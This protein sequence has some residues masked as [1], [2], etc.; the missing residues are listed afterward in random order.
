LLAGL[1]ADVSRVS[2]DVLALPIVASWLAGLLAC[3]LAGL[4]LTLPQMQP[5]GRTWAH[6][7]KED[8]RARL[9]WLDLVGVVGWLVVMG[10]GV[11][12]LW[13][14]VLLVG[15][16]CLVLVVCVCGG[17]PTNITQQFSS[18]LFAT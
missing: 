11:R 12:W 7:T 2:A 9:A 4:L 5:R 16:V 3:W 10:S 15:G 8:G 1:D 6:A 17:E 13:C 18:F 14:C